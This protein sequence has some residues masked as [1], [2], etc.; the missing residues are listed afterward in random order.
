MFYIF[1]C[2]Y[3]IFVKI[4]VKATFSITLILDTKLLI[5]LLLKINKMANNWHCAIKWALQDWL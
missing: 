3:H 1:F 5:D 2:K 4:S